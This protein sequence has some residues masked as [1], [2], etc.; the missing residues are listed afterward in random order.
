[1]KVESS[2]SNELKVLPSFLEKWPFDIGLVTSNVGVT[3]AGFSAS[4]ESEGRGMSSCPFPVVAAS[5]PFEPSLTDPA[6]SSEPVGRDLG[7]ILVKCESE[8]ETEEIA[9]ESV[10]PTRSDKRRPIEELS[11]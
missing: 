8:R 3:S 11:R 6:Q 10:E 7:L 2:A 5:V 1:M 4:C 9:F